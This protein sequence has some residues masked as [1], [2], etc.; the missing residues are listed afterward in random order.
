MRISFCGAARTVTGSKH[1]LTLDNGKKILFDCGMFQGVGNEIDK[2]NGE[3][4]FKADCV[5]YVFL[6]HAH[7]DHSG[8][9]PKLVK[10][11]FGGK[12][13][14]TPA[15][16]DLTVL[17]LEDSANIQQNDS[18]ANYK[19]KREETVV[20]AFYDLD[21]VTKSLPL[22][23]TMEYGKWSTIEEGI[24]VLFTDA[25]HIIGSAAIH[26]R[27]TE[28]NKTEQIT[29]TG[30]VGR[31][32][33]AILRAP[34][35][36]P[37]SDYIILESTYGNKLHEAVFSTTDHLKKIIK[38]TCVHKKGNLIIPAFSVGRTQELLYYL[39]Q[40]S[41]EKSLPD[42]PVIV[43][44]PLSLAATNIIKGYPNYFNER[45]Q[46]ILE[47]DD[48]PFDFPGLHF[49]QTV[50][51]SMKIKDI[52]QPCIIIAASGMAD[53]GRIRHHIMN[54]IHNE[55]NTILI[56]GYCDPSSLG[57]Q[58]MN[59]AKQVK[60]M[61]EDFKV[62]AEIVVMRSMSAHGD[63]DDLLRFL[64]CQN[65]QQVKKIFLVHGEYDVQLEFQKR[66]MLKE[67]NDVYIPAMHETHELE[68]NIGVKEAEVA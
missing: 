39:N 33:D 34:A 58:L 42:V 35:E 65:P 43:D 5:D 63:S 21:D 59:K 4:G 41:L 11:G 2:L 62:Y 48:D 23:Q 37:Q 25:G 8:L 3:F 15:T 24:E 60:I 64:A 32:R 57:G 36:F 40:L 1:L 19:N 16:R 68:S 18:D 14:C 10:E 66:L 61:G 45:I 17:L 50:E 51:D 38:D 12:I 49:T 28:N 20:N 9:L 6:S 67:F 46:K 22:F 13:F 30:D 52:T 55:K 56:V 26:L 53:A 27:I 54:N 47:V 7:I 31:Y 29:F 44:S